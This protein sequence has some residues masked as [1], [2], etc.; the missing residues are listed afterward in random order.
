MRAGR[1]DA[2]VGLGIE[3]RR[4]GWPLEMMVRAGRAGWRVTGVDVPY[5]PRVG[6]SKVTGTVKGTITAIA[7]QRRQLRR[8]GS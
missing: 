4:S 5:H 7:D 8:L 6:R 3:D 2:L 1:R